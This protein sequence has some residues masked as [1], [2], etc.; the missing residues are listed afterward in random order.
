MVGGRPRH[1][2]PAATT[3]TAWTSVTADA[4]PAPRRSLR[5]AP[6]DRPRRQHA[7]AR[8]AGLR[9]RARARLGRWPARELGVGTFLCPTTSSRSTSGIRFDDRA[10]APVAGFD[11]GV[12]RAGRRRRGRAA[13]TCAL[14]RRR[15]LLAERSGPR[16]ETP[17]EI[18]LIAEHADVVGMT[19]ASECV[20]AGELGLRY[21]AVC[22]VDNLANGVARAAAHGRGVRGGQA[23]RTASALAR[24]ARRVVPVLARRAVSLTVIDAALDGEPRRPARRGRHDRRAR[25]RRRGRATATR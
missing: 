20:V 1:R 13:P 3:S 9:P 16:F 17:A 12:A 15:R 7:V 6:P 4:G 25:S 18:R 24:G 19:I 11:S 14:R 22:I 10:L 2:S 23:R 5:P 8:R 21:A